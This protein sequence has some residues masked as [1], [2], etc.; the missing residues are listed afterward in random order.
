MNVT[1][2]EGPAGGGP[3][4]RRPHGWGGDLGVGNV[5]APRKGE[6]AWVVRQALSRPPASHSAPPNRWERAEC[7]IDIC[8]I[9]QGLQAYVDS[10]VIFSLA[11][12]LKLAEPASS[13]VN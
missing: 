10:A 11:M 12:W 2:W 3:R 6:E 13:L 8:S 7:V 9:G 5:R 1:K 4:Q